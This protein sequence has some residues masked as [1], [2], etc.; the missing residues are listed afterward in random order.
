MEKITCYRYTVAYYDD[1]TQKYRDHYEI[2]LRA[3][4]TEEY[5]TFEVYVPEDYEIVF[6]EDGNRTL[7]YL[8]GDDY[9]LEWGWIE[10]D[11]P[12]IIGYHDDNIFRWDTKKLEIVKE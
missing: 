5:D 8:G 6:D 11:C 10:P 3:P 4:E 2:T 12:Y 7:R 9:G 1:I